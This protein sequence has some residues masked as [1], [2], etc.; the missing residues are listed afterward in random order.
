MQRISNKSKDKLYGIV[1]EEIMQARIEIQKNLMNPEKID[2]ILFNLTVSAPQKA[3]S[4]FH[5]NKER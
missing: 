5:Y 1:H 2:S 3:I 4:C